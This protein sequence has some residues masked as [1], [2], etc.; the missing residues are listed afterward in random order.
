MTNNSC[1]SIFR[2]SKSSAR[3]LSPFEASYIPRSSFASVNVGS[4]INTNLTV[5]TLVTLLDLSHRLD[6]AFEALLCCC[7]VPFRQGS[8]TLNHMLDWTSLKA[9]AC[10]TTPKVETYTAYHCAF[11]FAQF[12]NRLESF[13]IASLQTQ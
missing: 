12:T 8:F 7:M 4:W 1:I 10:W 11:L 6:C 9:K 2:T 3:V 5:H 13:I